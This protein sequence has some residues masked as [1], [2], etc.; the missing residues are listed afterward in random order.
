[1]CAIPTS[2]MP[3]HL[4]LHDRVCSALDRCQESP[5]IDFKESAAWESLKLRLIRTILAMGNL[6]DGGVI[7]IGASERDDTWELTGISHEHLA[8]YDFDD[9]TDAI[10]KYA[11]P[12]M[13]IEIVLVKYR[14][15]KE[16]LAFQVKEFESLPYICKN[17]APNGNRLLREGEVYIR[18]PGKPQ[19]KK[20]SNAQE[21]GDLLEL[22]AEKRARSII[23]TSRRI[24][25]IPLPD[26]DQHFDR[27]L[28]GL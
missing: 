12:P 16:F 23:S 14:S 8:A 6:R 11:S 2:D 27:E 17:N 15:D 3:G 18:P 28:E 20:I 21:M 24:G 22:A 25:F 19:T 10:N 26:N 5:A 1:M 13:Q 9:I 4:Q 7:I